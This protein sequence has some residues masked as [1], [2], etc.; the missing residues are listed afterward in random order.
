AERVLDHEVEGHE[1]AQ[2]IAAHR[3]PGDVA[4]FAGDAL[5]RQL[6]G[7][8]LPVPGVVADHRD[9]RGVALV[10]G[11]RVGEV[12]DANAHGVPSTTTRASRRLRG[13]GTDSPASTSRTRGSQ[14]P[15]APP[16]PCMCMARTSKPIACAARRS[17][18]RP[19][20]RRRTS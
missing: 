8:K 16:G 1:V 11:A 15:P 12:V 3:A 6:T 4:E 14:A 17:W 13:G 2:R 20:S 19:A 7:E 18:V 5:G 10:A 9:V